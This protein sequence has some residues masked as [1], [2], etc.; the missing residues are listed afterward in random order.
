MED[1]SMNDLLKFD[2]MNVADHD[3]DDDYDDDD[4]DPDLLELQQKLGGGGDSN[5]DADA[6]ADAD[7]AHNENPSNEVAAQEEGS[8]EK[9]TSNGHGAAAASETTKLEEI[10]PLT[11]EEQIAKLQKENAQLKQQLEELQ[12]SN[13]R[14][15]PNAPSTDDLLAQI[16]ELETQVTTLQQEK[17]KLEQ[18][19]ASAAAQANDASSPSVGVGALFQKIHA[20]EA[21]NRCLQDGNSQLQSQVQELRQQPQST[22]SQDSSVST[23][24]ETTPTPPKP[25]EAAVSAK[26]TSTSPSNPAA[27][28]T[29]TLENVPQ[30]SAWQYAGQMLQIHELENTV[31]NL[32]QR[33]MVL[34][35]EKLELQTSLDRMEH[36]LKQY[37]GQSQT[38]FA[39]KRASWFSSSPTARTAMDGSGHPPLPTV[40][41]DET[42]SQ[43]DLLKH[44]LAAKKAR[45]GPSMALGSGF[46]LLGKSL[47]GSTDQQ[48]QQQ[49]PLNSTAGSGGLEEDDTIDGEMYKKLVEHQARYG[50]GSL[51][52]RTSHDDFDKAVQQFE[53]EQPSPVWREEIV[54][55]PPKSSL[56]RSG[57]ASFFTKSSTGVREEDSI[58]TSSPTKQSS[59]PAPLAIESLTSM[60][61]SKKN[62]REDILN[63]EEEEIDTID[64]HV[65]AAPDKSDL[66]PPLAEVNKVMAA[67]KSATLAKTQKKTPVGQGKTIDQSNLLGHYVTKKQGGTFGYLT[68][69]VYGG[70][71]SGADDN[72]DADDLLR[73]EVN[74]KRQEDLL[75]KEQPHRDEPDGEVEPS[76]ARTADSAG[77]VPP[78]N[79]KPPT[80]EELT[81][82][83]KPKTSP[84]G[85]L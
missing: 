81:E 14:A 67:H 12:L 83:N 78:N 57:F 70:D 39:A 10:T 82:T 53:E 45:E 65:S 37:K 52:I 79:P 48:Q 77:P 26:T 71:G 56:A 60:L 1:V 73:Q 41:V 58:F 62:S 24:A 30:S 50:N 18:Q 5:T 47:S 44:A 33:I 55:D 40:A 17:R 2:D 25:D 54:P 49:Q 20:L 27:T 28:T 84:S 59:K 4:D 74:R 85:G 21:M 19:L 69:L 13:D 16:S 43:T 76:T 7:A 51:N 31:R 46:G 75:D 80:F 6:D 38:L 11:P 23:Q 35:E 64:F 36:D 66:F 42:T 9:T 8:S 22:S 63:G 61:G 29:T 3:H 68:S 15:D 72:D 32:Q 34:V